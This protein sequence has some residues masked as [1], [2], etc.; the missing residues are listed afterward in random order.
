M[1]ATLLNT[2]SSCKSC[3]RKMHKDYAWGLEVYL[4]TSCWEKKMGK[5]HHFIFEPPSTTLVTRENIAV[6]YSVSK[7]IENFR[8]IKA[9]I[10][11]FC[12]R[13]MKTIS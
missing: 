1:Y 3:G 11:T 13:I 6:Y 8:E 12:M 4:N 7:M 5:K 2:S 9:K 10:K